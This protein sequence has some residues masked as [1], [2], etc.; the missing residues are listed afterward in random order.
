MTTR[1]TPKTNNMVKNNSK[2]KPPPIPHQQQQEKEEEEEGGRRTNRKKKE[3]ALLSAFRWARLCAANSPISRCTTNSALRFWCVLMVC[4]IVPSLWKAFFETTAGCPKFISLY[5]IQCQPLARWW[6]QRF[7]IFTPIWGRFPILTTAVSHWCFH[8]EK[9]IF[10]T[11]AHPSS[12]GH[13]S[14]PGLR[15]G[16]CQ[17]VRILGQD[18][19]LGTTCGLFCV[20][21]VVFTYV[22]N[23]YILRATAHAADPC[24]LEEE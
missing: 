17:V 2:V 6:F 14:G 23:I 24:N 16:R 15:S 11:L 4:H 10:R 7:F 13:S 5:V 3:K 20:G 1:T 8:G 12:A 18:Q 22:L 9:R 21:E 19:R